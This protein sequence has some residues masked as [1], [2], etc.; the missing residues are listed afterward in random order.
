MSGVYQAA[1]FELALRAWDLFSTAEKR[2]ALERY[3]Q[4]QY[5]RVED[6]FFEAVYSVIEKMP[7]RE[8]AEG[9]PR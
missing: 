2:Q 5:A 3:G 7:R 4:L 1:N 9:G 6:R 8:D